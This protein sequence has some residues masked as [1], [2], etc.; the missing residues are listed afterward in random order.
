MI[1]QISR[2]VTPI[3]RWRCLKPS[4]AAL[5]NKRLSSPL[6]V[7]QNFK[8]HSCTRGEQKNS[9]FTNPAGSSSHHHPNF[10]FKPIPRSN[11]LQSKKSLLMMASSPWEKLAIRAKWFLIKGYRPFNIDEIA[12]F[13]SWI[14]L[15]HILWIILGTTTFFSLLFY[16]LN[17]LFAK[18]LV[19]N[20]TGRILTSISPGFDIKFEDA[21][22]PEW[23]EGMIDFKKVIITTL[24]LIHI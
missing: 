19:G 13:F 16:G 22:V 18:E 14:I 23:K 2:R 5:Y 6:V 9:S 7:S 12:A 3:S 10:S 20:I 24:S 17:S 4:P 1:Q 11:A 21:V 8:I 15:S